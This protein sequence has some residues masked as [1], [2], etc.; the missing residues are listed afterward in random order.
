MKQLSL[1]NETHE[2]YST[3]QVIRTPDDVYR[4]ELRVTFQPDA[5]LS[6]CAVEV[7]HEHSRELV[8]WT[9]FPYVEGVS[10]VASLEEGYARLVHEITSLENP[11]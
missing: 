9:M 5:E 7:T 8:S 11:F 2:H 1:F 3:P 10:A 6:V 4:A